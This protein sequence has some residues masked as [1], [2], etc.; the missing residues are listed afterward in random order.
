MPNRHIES[1]RSETSPGLTKEAA[2]QTDE[3]HGPILRNL[4]SRLRLLFLNCRQPIRRHV[5]RVEV[6]K[7]GSV[8]LLAFGLVPEEDLVG[9]AELDPARRYSRDVPWN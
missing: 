5:R 8:G 7:H 2:A 4:P 6:A 3:S 9:I 1:D